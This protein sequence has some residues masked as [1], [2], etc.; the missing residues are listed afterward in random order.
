MKSRL[1]FAVLVT[2]LFNLSAF[3]EHEG[4][5]PKPTPGGTVGAGKEV[6]P[7]VPPPPLAV[8]FP[9]DLKGKKNPV[10]QIISP[11]LLP[12]DKKLVKDLMVKGVKGEAFVAIE[13]TSGNTKTD[14]LK[15][16]PG[17]DGDKYR[18][19]VHSDG[20]IPGLFDSEEKYVEFFRMGAKKKKL[21][22][23]PPGKNDRE[24]Q[25]IEFHKGRVENQMTNLKLYAVEELRTNNI[26]RE[27]WA[28]M[29]RPLADADTEKVAVAID[30]VLEKREDNEAWKGAIAASAKGAAWKSH[31][32]WQTL[33]KK[34]A[35]A[36]GTLAESKYAAIRNL[37]SLETYKALIAD[38]GSV[39]KENAFGEAI[40][41]NYGVRR[42]LESIA[43]SY[44]DAVKEGKAMH[45]LAGDLYAL[46]IFELLLKA[47]GEKIPLK[48]RQQGH[49]F[50]MQEG[51]LTDI[52][53]LPVPKVIEQGFDPRLVAPKPKE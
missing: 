40:I 30:R 10:L 52:T 24:K 36:Y 14:Y 16:V 11:S 27:A 47:A 51:V 50:E 25:A 33:L 35:E 28:A 6:V 39:E 26:K 34:V 41:Y 31:A 8:T 13:D 15:L 20:L 38:P 44:C 5:N 3:G 29:K 21:E 22:E 43:K 46:K 53:P 48:F 1:V 19:S 23:L 45:V 37:P 7:A 2:L 17:T 12:G 9:C 42:S 32:A 49:D 18:L 4:A